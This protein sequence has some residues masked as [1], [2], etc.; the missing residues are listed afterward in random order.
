MTITWSP[1]GL[2]AAQQVRPI[3]GVIFTPPAVTDISLRGM[4]TLNT[5]S[6]SLIFPLAPVN[7]S[8]FAA[9]NPPCWATTHEANNKNVITAMPRDFLFPIDSSFGNIRVSNGDAA[10]AHAERRQPR[11]NG[12]RRAN[13]T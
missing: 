9:S 13:V 5:P 7:C 1:I 2:N 6:F 8:I 12:E 10:G 11:P 3:G 4:L